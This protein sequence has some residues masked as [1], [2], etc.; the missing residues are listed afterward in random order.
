MTGRASRT[1]S[2]HGSCRAAYS[3]NR[4]PATYPPVS[5]RSSSPPRSRAASIR[6]VVD[7]ASPDVSCRSANDSGSSAWTTMDSERGTVDGLGACRR[8]LLGRLGHSQ[9]FIIAGTG[10]T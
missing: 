1:S 4:R 5:S 2:S 3:Q 9:S 7:L 6:E 10:L 8:R